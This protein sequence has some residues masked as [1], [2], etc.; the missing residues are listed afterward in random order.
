MRLRIEGDAKNPRVVNTETGEELAGVRSV[1]FDSNWAGRPK[2][3]IELSNASI[4]MTVSANLVQASGLDGDKY[5]RMPLR[6]V[7]GLRWLRRNDPE[8]SVQS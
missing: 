8:R 7:R 6:K 5:A 3:E 1:E 4:D 2:V